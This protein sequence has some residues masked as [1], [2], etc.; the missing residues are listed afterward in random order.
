[1]TNI[2]NLHLSLEHNL[3]KEKLIN[4]P[5][6]LIIQDLDGVCMGLVKDP[7]NRIIKWDYV[8]S[9]KKM[10]D[11]FFVLTNGEHIGKR[12]VNNIIE[13]SASSAQEVKETGYYLPGLAG[14]RSAVARLFW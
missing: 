12:G 6:S 4:T 2:K 10:K 14:G 1:M 3:L 13:K 9:A 5:N 11:H 8:Q 7:L